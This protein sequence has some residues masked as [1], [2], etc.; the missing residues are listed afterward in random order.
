MFN[1][2]KAFNGIDGLIWGLAA[3]TMLFSAVYV[4]DMLPGW[5]PLKWLVAGAIAFLLTKA[6]HV[7]YKYK[8][9]VQVKNEWLLWIPICAISATTVWGTVSTFHE[10]VVRNILESQE[11]QNLQVERD[12]LQQRLEKQIEINHLTKSQETSAEITALDEKM[13]RLRNLG[14][15]AKNSAYTAIAGITGWSVPTI[16]LLRLLFFAVLIDSIILIL[17]KISETVHNRVFVAQPFPLSHAV[18]GISGHSPTLPAGREIMTQTVGIADPR[19]FLKRANQKI[20]HNKTQRM[21]LLDE[22]LEEHPNASLS[23]MAGAIGVSRE[24]AR[25]YLKELQTR[26]LSRN[27]APQDA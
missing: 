21:R 11:Y 26:Q 23:Q 5:M 3:V 24:T 14:A 19:P 9:R 25:R 10:Q 6:W 18:V 15:G 1:P 27:G 20:Q 22:Y 13:Q 12:A 4:Y 7:L 16:A 17:I 8:L 2:R